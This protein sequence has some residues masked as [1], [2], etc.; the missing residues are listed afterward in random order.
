MNYVFAACGTIILLFIVLILKKKKKGLSDF[1]LIGVN[2]SVGMFL[3]A[4]IMVRWKLT[5]A[6]V[7]FQNAVPM[8]IFPVFIFYLL[9]FTHHNKR[10]KPSWFLLFLPLTLLLSLSFIDHYVLKNYDTIDAISQHFNAPSVWYHLLFKGSQLTFIITL[11]WAIR[12]LEGFAT[13]LKNGYSS[14]ETINVQWLKHFT[15]IYLISISLTFVLFLS[16]NLGL[17]PFEIN[18]VFGIVY[19]I[20]VI[21]VFYLNYQGIQHYT[22]SEFSSRLS[23]IESKN[24]V[25]NTTEEQISSSIEVEVESEMLKIIEEKELFLEPKFSLDDLA[26]QLNQNKH[27]VSKVINSKKGRSFYDLINGYRVE[28]LKKK[29]QDP[30]NSTYTILSLGLD[31]GF[32]SKAS[33][34]RIFK[35]YTGLTPK[36]YID[37][38]SQLIG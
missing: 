33:I 38:Q 13:E 37:Q 30:K 36:Q 26:D 11:I 10:I 3:L 5:S 24:V 8:L 22:I 20:L 23:P 19:G 7:I 31:S 21:S 15:W 2:I 29:L 16:Q 4:D 17:V 12:K 25:I 6:T 9:Q 32:N 14:I 28:Y 34:N 1:L 35:N 18:Q 27:L